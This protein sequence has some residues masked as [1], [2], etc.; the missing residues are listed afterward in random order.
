[1]E[2]ASVIQLVV[3][4]VLVTAVIVNVRTESKA[5]RAWL[6]NHEKRTEAKFSGLTVALDALKDDNNDEHLAMTQALGRLQGKVG[7]NG[8]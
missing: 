7:I 3:Y 6:A 8:G 5:T 1:M 4:A 2:L